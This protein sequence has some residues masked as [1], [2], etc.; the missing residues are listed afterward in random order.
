MAQLRDPK[1][2]VQ[3]VAIAPTRN[4]AL[5]KLEKAQES[6]ANWRN[7]SLNSSKQTLG[8][9]SRTVQHLQQNQSSQ[10]PRHQARK[11]GGSPGHPQAAQA[12]VHPEAWRAQ[13]NN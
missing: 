10:K 6:H 13:M 3:S 4:T 9:A 11:P 12:P 2:R 5:Q 7:S 8:V 1:K